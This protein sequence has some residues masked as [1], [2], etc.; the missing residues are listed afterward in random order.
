MS[1]ACEFCKGKVPDR[2]Y[3]LH[4]D[5]CPKNKRNRQQKV[6]LKTRECKECHLELA[7][8]HNCLEAL[9]KRV[10]TLETRV[11]CLKSKRAEDAISLE[12]L[13]NELQK[14]FLK[15]EE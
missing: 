5:H 1:R 4:V 15:G 10:N 2:H 12:N 7:S 14:L 3:Q 8:N 9:L 13:G 6:D 11:R